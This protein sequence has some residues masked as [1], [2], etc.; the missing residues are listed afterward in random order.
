MAP[1]ALIVLVYAWL[2]LIELSHIAHND[3]R[4]W[5]GR[6]LNFLYALRS[7][8][9]EN[10]YQMQHPG[11]MTMWAGAIALLVRQP[12][13]LSHITANNPRPST[14]LDQIW[15]E[16]GNPT[17][18][19][20]ALRASKVIMQT[21]F[22]AIAL[23]YCVPLV[24]RA[25]TILT[26]SLIAVSGVLIGWDS[27]LHLDG[28]AG[29]TAFAGILATAYAAETSD[30]TNIGRKINW[31]WFVAGAVCATSWLTRSTSLILVMVPAL[32]LL[33][34]LFS[35]RDA[36]PEVPLRGR[37]L[38]AVG[39][40]LTWAAGA[41]ISTV[42]LFPALWTRPIDTI[43]AIVGMP[44]S[45]AMGNGLENFFPDDLLDPGWTYYPTELFLRTTPFEWLG[46]LS[47][48]VLVVVA[49]KRGLISPP[50]LRLVLLFVVFAIIFVVAIS[51]SP[52][53]SERYVMTIYPIV[54]LIA[55][56]GL[57][58]LHRIL[59]ERF[60][61]FGQTLGAAICVL[62]VCYSVFISIQSLPYKYVYNNPIAL[63]AM[64][65]ER[66]YAPAPAYDQVAEYLLTLRGNEPTTIGVRRTA[67]VTMLNYYISPDEPLVY[68]I[69]PTVETPAEWAQIDYQ[70]VSVNYSADSGQSPYYPAE[71]M[72]KVS[73]DGQV[74]WEIYH[75][76]D[77]PVPRTALTPT[78]CTY[79]F[80]KRITLYQVDS[81]NEAL[82]LYFVADK[83]RPV[84]IEV[85]ANVDGEQKLLGVQDF[86]P[87]TS[88][89]MVIAK[90]DLPD[91]RDVPYDLTINIYDSETGEKLS[92]IAYGGTD[93]ADHATVQT[94]CYQR[95]A[96]E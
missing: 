54:S 44:V 58:A 9:F 50:A 91:T 55:S 73:V 90:F 96:G 17:E 38:V 93:S 76:L 47:V 10:T 72:H 60:Q 82:T 88:K 86:V 28:L 75:G 57:V 78:A 83:A 11:V 49:S 36:Q 22:F 8:E 16:G 40:G 53:K 70:M 1:Y 92:A 74:L 63:K 26:G 2:R 31:N 56:I 33:F 87:I 79:S 30:L 3:E 37:I 42:L 34:L 29:I 84:T 64:G 69:N 7:G 23:R 46:L 85:F 51:F 32:A 61:R 94:D 77:I 21:V 39:H 27:W 6:S 62:A 45:G 25:A 35:Q 66:D 67:W 68:V 12:E 15:R 43:R 71:P 48:V 80:G 89:V 95:A 14:Y 24:G 59:A 18:L 41:V 81:T 65:R 13:I 4:L 19:L 20:I 5:L 52:K